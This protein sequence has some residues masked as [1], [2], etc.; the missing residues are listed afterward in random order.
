MPLPVFRALDHVLVVEV[1]EIIDIANAEHIRTALVCQLLR[2][3]GQEASAVVVDLRDPFLT[4]A[5]VDVLEGIRDLADSVTVRLLVVAPHP[6][7]RRV[8]RLTAAD[9]QREV[10]PRLTEALRAIR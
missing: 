4:S 6:L 10:H 5:G 3:R 9:R 7:T 8:L 2:A 1:D